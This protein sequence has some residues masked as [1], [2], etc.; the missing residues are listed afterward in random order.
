MEALTAHNAKVCLTADDMEG[1][2]VLYPV[3]TGLDMTVNTQKDW[4]CGKS[5]QNIGWVRVLA[6]IFIPVA[7]IMLCELMV[8]SRL[9]HH[10]EEKM[11]KK[12]DKLAE[13]NVVAKAAEK[14]ANKEEKK[15]HAAQAALQ[16]QI[17][18][19]DERVEE[20]AQELAAAR[21][22]AQLKRKKA[23]QQANQLKADRNA[24]E[25]AGETVNYG[26]SYLPTKAAPAGL[27]SGALP[28]TRKV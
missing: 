9:K 4:N 15:A 11:K 23:Q 14:K 19:E 3:C 26:A 16:S 18:T 21:I 22:Q 7:I 8:L 25:Q 12:D 13:V 6:W 24:R 28:Q 17:A 10:E 5:K 1:L 27:P 20:R 2:N